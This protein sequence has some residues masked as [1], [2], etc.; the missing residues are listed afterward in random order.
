M[1]NLH[2][3]GTCIFRHKEF[4]KCTYLQQS[5]AEDQDACAGYASEEDKITCEI[6]GRQTLRRNVVIFN[7]E[8]V[9]LVCG[10]CAEKNGTCQT[11]LERKTCP[12]ETDPSPLPKV[13][14]KRI[15]QGPMVQIMQIKNPERVNITCRAGCP[16]W[17]EENFTCGKEQGWCC[18]HEIVWE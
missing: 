18:Q 16:C 8:R 13:V 12:F 7:E 15:Q 9:H 10:D 17:D 14:Q 3:C 6:C 5:V 2:K 4:G 1:A 11:C